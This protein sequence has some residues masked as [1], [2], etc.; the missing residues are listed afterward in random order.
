[1]PN[2]TSF[3]SAGRGATAGRAAQWAACS[4]GDPVQ[5]WDRAVT[6][7]LKREG[8]IPGLGFRIS[9]VVYNV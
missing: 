4:Q 6:A 1:M 5:E 9:V 3:S 2:P 7:G 8:D